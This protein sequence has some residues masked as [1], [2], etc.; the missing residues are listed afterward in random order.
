[1][2]DYN[3]KFYQDS[4]LESMKII[5]KLLMLKKLLKK[6]S[7]SKKSFVDTKEKIFKEINKN[8]YEY[9]EGRINIK[10]AFDQILSEERK[11]YN[12]KYILIEDSKEGLGNLYEPLYNFFFLLQKDNSLMMKLIEYS[13]DQTS[14]NSELSDFLVHFLYVDIIDCSFNE[15]RLML[16]IYLLLEKKFLE[17]SPD[18]Y[19][20]DPF[21][22]NVFKS[23]TRKVD[24][25]NFLGS[26]LNKNIMKI[27]NIRTTLSLDINIVNKNLKEMGNSLYHNM[28]LSNSDIDKTGFQ[29]KKKLFKY[30]IKSKFDKYIKDDVKSSSLFK[31]SSKIVL[32]PNNN[33]N[34]DNNEIL[35]RQSTDIDNFEEFDI[36]GKIE[37]VK[38]I[39][40]KVLFKK[41]KSKEKNEQIKEKVENKQ[42]H[43][44]FENLKIQSKKKSGP[45]DIIREKIDKK[46]LLYQSL[47]ITKGDSE[48]SINK[49]YNKK[50]TIEIDTFFEDNNITQQKIT[51]IL[52]NY[53]NIKNNENDKIN[54]AMREYLENLI[55][56][57]DAE[58][59]NQLVIV[60]NFFDNLDKNKIKDREIFSS[61]FYIEELKTRQSIQ[62]EDNFT[63]LMKN[64]L[65]HHHIIT[66]IVNNIIRSI[67]KNLDNFP[68][69]IKC[70]FKMI[71]VLLNK[72]YKTNNFSYYK[73]YIIKMNFLIGNIILPI[74]KDPN[75]NGLIS[76][77]L[78]DVTTKN[79]EIVHDIFK[80]MISGNLFNRDKNSS[81]VLYNMFII[82]TLPKIFEIIDNFGKNFELPD[83]LKRLINS[84][85]DKDTHERN[86]NY[87]F[88]EE[89]P[90]E[91]IQFNCVCFSLEILFIFNNIIGINTTTLIEKNNDSNQKTILNNLME[92][93][94]KT[95]F[96]EKYL[97][98]K[99]EGKMKYFY[100]TNIS[101]SNKIQKIMEDISIK[102]LNKGDIISSYKTCLI[103]VL[104]YENYNYL[105]EF[106]KMNE[107]KVKKTNEKKTTN[108][109][110]K[111][112][113]GLR[114][115]L[116]NTLE[117]ID[118][119]DADF[120]KIILPKIENILIYEMNSEKD[121]KLIIFCTNYLKLNIENIPDEYSQYNYSLLFSE[122][123]QE[124]KN[125]I[126]LLNSIT[127]FENY[128]KLNG[129]EKKNTLSTH[130]SKQIQFLEKL[131][132]TEYLYKKL[133]LPGDFNIEKDANNII[134]KMQFCPENEKK[135]IEYMIQ[136]FP[137]FSAYEN[138][139]DN[140]LDIEEKAEVPKALKDY[141]FS[142]QNLI[143]QDYLFVK[144]EE[145]EKNDI[146]FDL[147]NYILNKLYGKLFPLQ[148]SEEDLLIY[149]KCEKLSGIRPEQI[150][151]NKKLINP[152]LLIEASKYFEQLNIGSTPKEKLDYVFKGL[153]IIFNLITLTTGKEL[154]GSDEVFDPF[155]YT[156]IIAK[157]KKL[158]S[159]V[160]YINMFLNRIL[161][162]DIYSRF[163]YDLASALVFIDN[164]QLQN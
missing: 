62:I 11:L 151:D 81:M 40:Q 27:Q 65:K 1:M 3:Q 20:T 46:K 49:N 72:Q 115:S 96:I 36:I 147:E 104:S 160:Q 10:K 60:D 80:K 78:S 18:S 38:D 155:F 17:T 130:F 109:K 154:I 97:N 132:Y 24:V 58:K 159:N 19:L 123:I 122:L 140:I 37:E 25:R 164:L 53:K 22:I 52:N 111:G 39:N 48:I 95:N 12:N 137:D 4:D 70:I 136:N 145:K 150:I 34:T 124:T 26:I 50:G 127:I 152:N 79:I 30:S 7:F 29:S 89:K 13:Q 129:A 100:F 92:T 138:E 144:L 32:I 118:E 146:A 117:S 162:K 103:E 71:D 86:I 82:E 51:E 99:E 87:N 9:L 33:N 102:Q 64:I 143:K 90:N 77:I 128:D 54:L 88:F 98:E 69:I 113:K 61:S 142:M 28:F 45:E 57:L 21:L 5:D 158:P 153:R 114:S 120:K 141:F 135:D 121:N 131:Q 23:L 94:L 2:D 161:V 44:D 74:L 163:P 8:C 107:D 6:L 112:K 85:D 31:R 14:Y 133:K 76:S 59:K 148:F 119:D 42:M 91:N 93:L 116:I 68:Y 110:L 15:D 83:Y 47:N 43:L 73:N 105:I 67:S 55:K 126:Q 84:I 35:K 56:V 156:M 125:K 41:R 63:K 157:V 75:Y 106:Q 134:T 108:I 101:Y 149:Q 16:M 139:Y 66:V